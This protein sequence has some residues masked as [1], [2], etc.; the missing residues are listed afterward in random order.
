MFTSETGVSL[1]SL[2]FRPKS[3]TYLAQ[4]HHAETSASVAVV[5]TLA[6]ILDANPTEM[7]QLY[8]SV[9]GEVLDRHLVGV[10]AADADVRVEF[11]FE[12]HAAAVSDTEVVAAR[13]GDIDRPET[14]SSV[15]A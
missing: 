7:D 13:A 2:S 15:S 10:G 1:D 14:G 11:V 12:R 5:A 4:Y 6:E 3:E 8:H 9:D